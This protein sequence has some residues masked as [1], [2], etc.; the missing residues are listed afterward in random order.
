M[1]HKLNTPWT[2]YGFHPVKDG[3][4]ETFITKIAKVYTAEEFW[5]AYCRIAR[6][7]GVD[8]VQF[9]RNDIRALWEDEGN[10]DGGTFQFRFQVQH[11]YAAWEKL[12]L[13]LI[14]EHVNPDII[15]AVL[16]RQNKDQVQIVLWNR[17]S[18]DEQLTSELA[19][20]LF[21]LMDMPFKSQVRYR[22]HQSDGRKEMKTWVLEADGP[23]LLRP[24][25]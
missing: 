21:K 16:S 1:S 24:S 8:A 18:Q 4:Y 10:R 17:T 14:G 6:P 23:V 19:K 9:F 22:Q 11:G 15:G 20:Q 3:D 2:F 7:K 25:S 12:L 5:A 13:G